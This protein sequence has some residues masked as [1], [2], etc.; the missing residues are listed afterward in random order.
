MPPPTRLG[1]ALSLT[2]FASEKLLGL[3]LDNARAGKFGVDCLADSE[4]VGDLSEREDTARSV[5]EGFLVSKA[6]GEAEDDFGPAI[7]LGLGPGATG[8]WTTFPEESIILI[9]TRLRTVV[10]SND[11]WNDDAAI[12]DF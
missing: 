10:G 8:V 7:P 2:T 11:T 4:V 12:F 5:S 9:G 6:I 3:G 1:L